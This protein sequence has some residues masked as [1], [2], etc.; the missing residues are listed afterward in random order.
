MDGQMDVWI[1]MDDWLTKLYTFFE[2]LVA[3]LINA[4]NPKK[5]LRKKKE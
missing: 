4:L 5:H 1:T 3:Y 2:L